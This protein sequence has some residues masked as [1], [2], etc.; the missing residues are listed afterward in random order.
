MIFNEVIGNINEMATILY[1]EGIFFDTEVYF[2]RKVVFH[3]S[4]AEL[5]RK[6]LPNYEIIERYC[7]TDIIYVSRQLR[8]V[9]RGHGSFDK[10]HAMLLYKLI[11]RL[12]LMTSFILKMNDKNIEIT[13]E[14]QNIGGFYKIQGTMQNM[15][16][17][18]SPFLLGT[19]NNSI[20][21]FNNWQHGAFEYINYLDGSL[22]LPSVISVPSSEIKD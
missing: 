10:N 12:A 14:Q 15:K 7:Y 5:I 2:E 3:D 1:D 17:E 6:Y 13:N 4:D 19:K 9:L 20:I 18:L 8:N 16:R 21:V 22:I 11:F